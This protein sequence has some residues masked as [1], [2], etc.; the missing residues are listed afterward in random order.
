MGLHD[1]LTAE[2]AE[3][4]LFSSLDPDSIQSPQLALAIAMTEF[5]PRSWVKFLFMQIDTF[6]EL[7]RFFSLSCSLELPRKQV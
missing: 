1:T 4:S 3:T 5:I 7:F 6:V 2:T